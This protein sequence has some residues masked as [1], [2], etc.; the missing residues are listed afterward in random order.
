MK[1]KCGDLFATGIGCIALIFSGCD[2]GDPNF[3]KRVGQAEVIGGRS[4]QT[5]GGGLMS[6]PE[7]RVKILGGGLVTGGVVLEEDGK[8]RIERAEAR[9][10]ENAKSA[11]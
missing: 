2:S 4:A 9:L 8:A 11:D 6:A 3:D 5:A 10:S 7:P 1:R